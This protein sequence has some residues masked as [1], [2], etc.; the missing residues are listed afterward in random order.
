MR[1]PAK[2]GKK[3]SDERLLDLVQRQTFRYF[4]EGA[5]PISGLARDR[6]PRTG[7]TADDLVAIGGSGF[8]AMAILVACE[9]GWVTRAQ[10]RPGFRPCWIASRGRPAITACIPHFMHGGTGATIPFSRKDDGADLVETP[11]LFRGCCARAPISTATRRR[12]AS[13]ERIT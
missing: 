7:D 11:F 6:R 3:L 8:G 4:W 1:T 2:R 10:A 12:G 9:R 5:H 13:A